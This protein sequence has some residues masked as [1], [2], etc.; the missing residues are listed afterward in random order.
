MGE[1]P[2]MFIMSGLI[3]NEHFIW[4]TQLRWGF[5]RV[6]GPFGQSELAGIMLILGLVLAL[7]LSYERL[8]E[9][10]FKH[11]EWLPFKKGTIIAWTIF[12]T[13]LM[14]QARGPWIGALFAVPIALIGRTRNMLRTSILVGSLC[15]V[16]GAV[17]YVG[18]Q[19]YA[20]APAAS[21]EQETASYRAQLLD[22]YIPVAKQGGPWGWGQSFP[23]APGQGSID[24]E[25]LFLALTQGWVGL[26]SFCLLALEAVL[27]D[28]RDRGFAISLVGALVGLLITIFT[29]FLGNQPYQIF[30]LLVG[31]SQ[32]L[33]VVQRRAQA[34]QM[35]FQQVY[36]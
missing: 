33:N 2:F 11:A 18:L 27:N 9:P 1:N 20:N 30:F 23:R 17:G 34:P 25:Y 29:V 4:K 10:K 15:L 24:N 28:K 13:L 32:A 31:W 5:G 6:S 19:H 26:V 16:V 36:T 21:A 7:W 3:P 14:T 8:W 22:N 35:A 12:L